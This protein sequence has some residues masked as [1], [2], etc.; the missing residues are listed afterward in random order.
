MPA[1]MQRIAISM[2]LVCAIAISA[3]A[4][5]ITVTNTN[6]SGP[7]S[8]RRALIDSQDGNTIDFDSSLKGQNILEVNSLPVRFSMAS[9]VTRR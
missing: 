1:M 4:T 6:D 5:T 3:D 7:G 2:S 8:L 9:M